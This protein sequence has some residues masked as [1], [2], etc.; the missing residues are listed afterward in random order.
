MLK[1][2]E[3]IFKLLTTE[4]IDLLKCYFCIMQYLHSIID[5]YSILSQFR[6]TTVA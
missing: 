1:N 3:C 2:S 4:S 6:L 5:I